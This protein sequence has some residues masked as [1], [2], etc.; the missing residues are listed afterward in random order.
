MKVLDV[1]NLLDEHFPFNTACDFDNVGLL[2][3][4]SNAEVTGIVT[5]LDC[6][7]EVLDFAKNS[8]ANLVVCHH[9]VIFDPI[10]RL[11]SDLVAYKAVNYGISVISA[12]TNLDAASG[13]VNDCLCEKIGL[14]NVK[15]F[16][17]DGFAMRIGKVKETCTA[18]Q[19]ALRCKEALNTSG[20]N[21]TCNNKPIKTVAVCSGGGKSV[22]DDV[23]NSS[24][25][26]F[27]TGE[28]K[29]SDLLYADNLGFNIIECGHFET[30]DVVVAPLCRL[31]ADNFSS[32]NVTEYHNCGIKHV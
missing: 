4:D 6:T 14:V 11:T 28:L 21:F 18:E 20:V 27:V 15:H 1:Y 22:L 26:A 24:A 30:E 12:H 17:S 16:Y 25:D 23:L 32:I 29:Y 2:I 7:A 19:L 5:A 8:G 31:L 13:G 10:K 3:G 9:P